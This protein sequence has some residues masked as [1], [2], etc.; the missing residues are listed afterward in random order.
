MKVLPIEGEFYL[1]YLVESRSQP[2][3]PHLVDLSAKHG[4]GECS[5]K[6]WQCRVWPVIKTGE[7]PKHSRKTTCRH[8][9]AALR[10]FLN[11]ALELWINEHSQRET[12]D[13]L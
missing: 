8:V 7:F 4:Y 9:Q 3:A 2:D 5:C 11:Y 13:P 10:Y 1:R 6:H 12:E